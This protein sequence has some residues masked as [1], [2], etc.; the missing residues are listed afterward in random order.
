M[1]CANPDTGSAS[2]F[3][4]GQDRYAGRYLMNSGVPL[5]WLPTTSVDP[6]KGTQTLI[7]GRA[8]LERSFTGENEASLYFRSELPREHD[9][10]YDEDA[11]NW[12][13][14]YWD[15]AAPAL[16]ETPEACELEIV[17]IPRIR[18]DEVYSFGE[19]ERPSAI[20]FVKFYDPKAVLDNMARGINSII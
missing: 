7:D 6:T 19:A 4:L 12:W 10:G 1:G 11:E 16:L 17:E 8:F 9:S 20:M 5:V 14:I 18:G 15:V 2:E 3:N 13:H